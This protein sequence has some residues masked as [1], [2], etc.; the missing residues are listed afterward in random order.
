MPAYSAQHNPLG[1]FQVQCITG[2]PIYTKDDYQ[3]KAFSH[4]FV[5]I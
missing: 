4:P 5:K 1:K 2:I 3:R